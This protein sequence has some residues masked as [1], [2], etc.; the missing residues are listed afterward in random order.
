[1]HGTSESHGVFMTTL[2]LVFIGALSTAIGLLLVLSPKA[3]LLLCQ[4]LTHPLQRGWIVE[5]EDGRVEYLSQQQFD[6]E[7]VT[8]VEPRPASSSSSGPT[9]SNKAT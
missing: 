4:S 7:D 2:D 8:H 5:R 6:E 9:P 1:M 3:R